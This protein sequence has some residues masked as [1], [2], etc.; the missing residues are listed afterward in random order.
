[1]TLRLGLS[2]M[3]AARVLVALLDEVSLGRLVSIALAPSLPVLSPQARRIL[4][5]TRPDNWVGSVSRTRRRRKVNRPVPPPTASMP[6]P[7]WSSFTSAAGLFQPA[8]ICTAIQFPQLAIAVMAA[9][10]IRATFLR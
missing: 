7:R 4:L 10:L 3:T 9:I 2:L 1:M 8:V 5:M 6:L